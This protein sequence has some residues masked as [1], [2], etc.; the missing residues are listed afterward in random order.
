MI[1]SNTVT[2]Y[3]LTHKSVTIK[4]KR[5]RNNKKRLKD[6]YFLAIVVMTSTS[7]RSTV[8]LMPS[9]LILIAL[10]ST[11]NDSTL[12]SKT[13]TLFLKCF[14]SGLHGPPNGLHE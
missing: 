2:L 6:S 12:F 7:F 8:S 1:R 5:I 13:S 14:H 4:S 3:L 11:S 10:A 9:R